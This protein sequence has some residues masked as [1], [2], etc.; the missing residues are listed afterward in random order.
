[1]NHKEESNKPKN[2]VEVA[3][4]QL[5]KQLPLIEAFE[6]LSRSRDFQAFRKWSFEKV[7]TLRDVLEVAKDDDLANVRGQLQSLK[8]QWNYF[9]SLIE[10]KK[11]V[12][13]KLEEL[14]EA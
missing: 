12:L 7:E 6:R 13:Q 1:M 14:K 10:H 8:G 11:E 2:E 3:R 9:D 4:E 5:G